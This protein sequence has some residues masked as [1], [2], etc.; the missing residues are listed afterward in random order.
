MAS[1]K[2]EGCKWLVVGLVCA[3]ACGGTVEAAVDGGGVVDPGE[4][5]MGPGGSP[6]QAGTT[7]GSIP[8]DAGL[9]CILT[10]ASI[11]SGTVDPINP[12]LFCDPVSHAT[13]WSNFPDGMV[14]G[15]GQVCELGNCVTGCFIGGTLY[16][17]GAVNPSDAC[18]S[19]DPVSDAGSW[20]KSPDGTT[21]GTG[22]VCQAGSCA[23]GCFI[24]G[25][26]VQPGAADPGDDCQSC[27]PGVSTTA[28][29]P[30]ADD[31]TCSSS[32]GNFCRSGQCVAGCLVAGTFEASGRAAAA[33]DCQICAPAESS[34]SF[35]TAPDGTACNQGGTYCEG[36][37]C[38]ELCNIQGALIGDG[39]MA[40]RNPNACCNLALSSTAWS[41]AFEIIGGGAPIQGF[42]VNSGPALADVTNDGILDLIVGETSGVEFLAG[43]GKGTFNLP[44]SVSIAATQWVQVAD[45]NGD[46]FPD[47]VV[48]TSNSATQVASVVVMLNSGQ[49][50]SLTFSAA[51]TYGVPYPASSVVV[52]NFVA[53][54]SHD[55][56]V[57][58]T[59]AG[60]FGEITLLA[61]QGNG[62]FA[63]GNTTA[64][65]TLMPAWGVAGPFTGGAADDLVVVDPTNMDVVVLV[66]GNI[67]FGFGSA[68]SFLPISQTGLTALALGPP[69]VADLNRD[70]LPDIV[71]ADVQLDTFHV[72][73]NGG[74]GNLNNVQT[75]S[76]P[77]PFQIVVGD[78]NGDG[79]P[80]I[81]VNAAGGIEV[82]M[83]ET[84][85]SAMTA[86]FATPGGYLVSPQ[87]FAAGDVN[88]D[89]LVDMVC[90]DQSNTTTLLGD[91][92]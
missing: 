56:A 18:Q 63:A 80:D 44:S 66:Y 16:L 75:F 47:V 29:T 31:T 69:V 82:F 28:W 25:S 73:M 3:S 21:C 32:G 48:L 19:C 14:C 91:C 23:S 24:G 34:T 49:P 2:N 1:F 50:D 54:G 70:G 85:I 20:T 78:F 52:G 61:N 26:L 51:A 45:V 60:G 62:T 84:P 9:A 59:N 41:P 83:N 38:R 7:A 27:D 81:A 92:P 77:S 71:V 42:P 4:L 5:Q 90:V 89:G 11:P 36:G 64:L 68:F 40:Y 39:G 37:Y 6:P 15:S 79:W 76:S 46:G 43:T 8:T 74:G 33:N 67:S 53:A 65:P 58:A 57:V 12:C 87:A 88:G 30:I 10:G 35:S 22:Q 55:I 17:T 72:L 13:S 86:T